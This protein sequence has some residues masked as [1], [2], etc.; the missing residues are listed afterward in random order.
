MARDVISHERLMDLLTYDPDDGVFTARVSLSKVTRSGDR[1]GTF[2]P[3]EGMTVT[4]DGHRYALHN[5]AWLYV[6]GEWPAKQLLK[7]DGDPRNTA[8]V[9][10]ALPIA[11][12][13][14]ELTQDRLKAVLNYERDTGVFTWRVRPAKNVPIGSIAGRVEKTNGNLYCAV[15]GVDYTVQRLAWLYEYGVIPDRPLRFM[16]GDQTNVAISNL[17]LPEHDTRTP[18][19]RVKYERDYRKR[20]FSVIRAQALRR[21]FGAEIADVYMRLFEAQGG[22]CAACKQPETQMRNGKVKWLAVDHCHE[23]DVVRGLLCCDCNIAIGKMR[24]DPARLRAAADY[25]EKDHTVAFGGETVV[26]RSKSAKP[27]PI[28][29][30]A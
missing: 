26:R 13:R 28:E 8:I 25:L 7:L 17:A 12:K 16:D 18:E 9:N 24:D 3:N 30:A 22:V 6:H 23:T 29:E 20:S 2:L 5:L 15:D 14:G 1:V 19:G 21:D 10:L 27:T 11:A 4:L